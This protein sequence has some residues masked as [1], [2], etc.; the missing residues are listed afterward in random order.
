MDVLD[1]MLNALDHRH[2]EVTSYKALSF[3]MFQSNPWITS[4]VLFCHV[5]SCYYS[6][7]FVC[8]IINV[9]V[10]VLIKLHWIAYFKFFYPLSDLYVV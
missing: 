4:I 3:R 2:P 6:N 1:E 7:C 5:D 8:R 10:Q 9:V